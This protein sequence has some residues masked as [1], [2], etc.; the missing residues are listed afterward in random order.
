MKF[1]Y[2]Y[3]SF[4]VWSPTLKGRIFL[5]TAK[6]FVFVNLFLTNFVCIFAEQGLRAFFANNSCLLR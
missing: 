6:C 3:W 4:C 2:K 1:K 5:I